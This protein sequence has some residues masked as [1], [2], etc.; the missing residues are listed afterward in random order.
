MVSPLPAAGPFLTLVPPVVRSIPVNGHAILSGARS[1]RDLLDPISPVFLLPILLAKSILLALPSE[2]FRIQPPLTGPSPP[3]RANLVPGQQPPR[4]SLLPPLTPQ[5]FHT[6]QPYG[7]FEMCQL[8]QYLSKE[9]RKK[10]MN[11]WSVSH[12]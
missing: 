2:R 10:G 3:P 11:E 8:T 12:L 1:P 9:R 7:W 4:W 6:A 5:A